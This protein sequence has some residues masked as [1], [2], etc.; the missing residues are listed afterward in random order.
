MGMKLPRG[1]KVPVTPERDVQRATVASLSQQH[2][3]LT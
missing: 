2:R 3:S 1:A